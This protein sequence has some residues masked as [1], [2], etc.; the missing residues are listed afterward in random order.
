MKSIYIHIPFCDTICHYCDFCKQYYYEKKVDMYLDALEQ[1]IKEL[2]KGETITTLYI[3][4]GTPSCLNIKQ[5][6]K[7]FAIIQ[8]ISLANNYEMTFELNIENTTKEKLELLYQNKVN[9]LSF[10]I[11]TFHD[12]YHNF[13]NR[14]TSYK[15]AK[16]IVKMARL[17]GFNNINGDLIYALKD[18]SIEEVKEDLDKILSLDLEHISTYSLIIE[19]H[20]K[21]YLDNNTIFN[22]G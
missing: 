14:S 19:P 13:L 20:T 7:L 8:N 2:Y 15:K 12:K 6:K 10:G 21:L 18:E 4:G 16:E 17:I 3:G 1:E 11:E 9:R 5:L 22:C